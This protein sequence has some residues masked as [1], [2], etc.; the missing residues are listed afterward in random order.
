[1]FAALTIPFDLKRCFFVYVCSFGGTA[2]VEMSLEMRYSLWHHP[3][4]L[5]FREQL[6]EL[7][8]NWL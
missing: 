6:V 3:K 4:D 8:P 1:M 7:F 5:N 2:H